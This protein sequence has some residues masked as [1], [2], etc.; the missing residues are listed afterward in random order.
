MRLLAGRITLRRRSVRHAITD[1]YDEQRRTLLIQYPAWLVVALGLAGVVTFAATGFLSYSSDA[2]PFD[3]PIRRLRP[4]GALVQ[5][6]NCAAKRRA[7]ARPS[8][9]PIRFLDSSGS[10]AQL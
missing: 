10:S 8:E 7:V 3:K 9:V 2:P 6:S 1:L 5:A 4:H